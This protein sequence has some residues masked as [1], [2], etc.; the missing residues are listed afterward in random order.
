MKDFFLNQLPNY[1]YFK[2]KLKTLKTFKTQKAT[3]KHVLDKS[4]LSKVES[5][6]A[7]ILRNLTASLSVD[8]KTCILLTE[9]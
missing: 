9:V 4:C 8:Q 1:L 7:N 6:I 5:K 2:K 3:N